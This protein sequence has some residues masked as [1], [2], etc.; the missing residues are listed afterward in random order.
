MPIGLF[1][2][3]EYYILPDNGLEMFANFESYKIT[4]SYYKNS[5]YPENWSDSGS[6]ELSNFYP[7]QYK[8]RITVP[9]TLERGTKYDFKLRL[10]VTGISNATFQYLTA[11]DV[12]W[13]TST[14]TDNIKQFTHSSSGIFFD[15]ED[16]SFDSTVKYIDV[17]FNCKTTSYNPTFTV[18]TLEI[19]KVSDSGLLGG[20]VEFVKSI[21]Q[22]II[23]LPMN[24]KNSLSSLFN[25]I[26]DAVNSIGISIVN[27][28]TTLGNFL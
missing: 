8:V 4:Y 6:F 24:I 26:K 15:F 23:D 20:I 18:G 22:G 2:G 1:N 11:N 25:A 14:T 10:N 5:T 7:T 27:A 3:V 19:S 28:L 13:W 21:L 17:V 9:E 16:L 12:N